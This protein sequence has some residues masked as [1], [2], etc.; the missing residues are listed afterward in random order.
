MNRLAIATVL[1]A[2][3]SAFIQ[4]CLFANDVNLISDAG[5]ENS[6]VLNWTVSNA[7][8]A[9]ISNQDFLQGEQAMFVDHPGVPNEST[10]VSQTFSLDRQ[11]PLSNNA[12]YIF[13]VN[14]RVENGTGQLA[15]FACFDEEPGSLCSQIWVLDSATNWQKYQIKFGIPITA[16]NV[17]FGVLYDSGSN[18]R[19]W[20]DWFKLINADSLLVNGD[21]EAE[22]GMWDLSDANVTNKQSYFGS[23]SL[24]IVGQLEQQQTA[25]QFVDLSLNEAPDR[26]MYTLSAHLVTQV[27]E[28]SDYAPPTFECNSDDFDEEIDPIAGSGAR[29]QVTC[30]ENGVPIRTLNFPFFESHCTEFIGQQFSF[31]V[32]VGTDGLLVELVVIDSD[33]VVYWDNVRLTESGQQLDHPSI[34]KSLVGHSAS[35]V[36]APEPDTFIV[37]NGPSDQEFDDAVAEVSDF[38]SFNYGRQI[39]VPRGEYLVKRI[40]PLPRTHLKM[41]PLACLRRDPTGAGGFR[42]VLLRS[43]QNHQFNRVSDVT[44]E[45]GTYLQAQ[46]TGKP[47]NDNL[48]NVVALFG[49]RIVLR[50]FHIPEWSQTTRWNTVDDELVEASNSDIAVTFLG[51]DVYVCHNS[52]MGPGGNLGDGSG[53]GAGGFGGLHLFGGN[54][55]HFIGN[56]VFSGDDA[57]GL[58]TGT[59]PF[60]NSFCDREPR[61][62]FIYNRNIRDVEILNNQLGSVSARAIGCGLA[63]P[64]DFESDLTAVVENVRARFIRGRQGGQ[65]GSLVVN[66][67]PRRPIPIFEG[68]ACPT[69]EAV[70]KNPELFPQRKPQ[71]RNILFADMLLTV[72]LGLQLDGI[73]V[74]QAVR[75][76][77][78]DIGSVENVSLKNIDVR[79]ICDENCSWPIADQPKELLQVKR[80]GVI[81]ENFEID[82]ETGG[83]VSTG[84][85]PVGISHRNFDICISGCQFIDETSSFLNAGVIESTEAQTETF[86]D[87][88]DVFAD[89]IFQEGLPQIWLIIPDGIH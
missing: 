2:F 32:P 61:R 52:V 40:I 28:T 39:W 74:Q 46:D 20:F 16:T 53:P 84:F 77:T 83:L 62:L 63:R 66:C 13:S 60:R 23:Q 89:N 72:D 56:D 15:L 37:V 34:S 71:V 41:H 17:S 82:P 35:V 67:I 6:S 73:P 42:G 44:V 24:S 45:G 22:T 21:F 4:S 69:A 9:G 48:G 86:D 79:T 70:S 65:A 14:A 88:N 33:M 38:N 27:S 81:C 78:E 57:I 75:I 64:R 5:F 11:S 47:N 7:E 87:I 36:E 18:G 54:R 12:E 49:D 59:V 25:S 1:F 80:A 8:N 58:Y 85:V 68:E 50:N 26:R 43:D 76:Y 31:L 3:L 30:C 55:V 51:N 19:V 29:M 10:M